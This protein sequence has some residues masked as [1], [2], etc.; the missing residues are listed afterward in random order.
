[1]HAI[2][3]KKTDIFETLKR[4][5]VESNLREIVKERE[6]PD[7]LPAVRDLLERLLLGL[8]EKYESFINAFYNEGKPDLN[9]VSENLNP[10]L[11]THPSILWALKKI[12]KSSQ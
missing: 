10:A 11:S 5:S 7:M 6:V 4:V 12:R 2:N 8:D 3:P 1:M 9:A